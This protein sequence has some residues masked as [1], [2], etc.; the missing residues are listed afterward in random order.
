MEKLFADDSLSKRERVERT[1]N[2]Q[3]LDRAA[4]HEQLSFNAGVISLYTGKQF[5]GFTYTYDDICTVIRRTV[6]ACFPP[7]APLGT[8]RITDKDGFVIQRDNWHSMIVQR[9]FQDVAGARQFLLRKTEKMRKEGPL[10]DRIRCHGLIILS[11]L[12]D[13]RLLPAQ[14]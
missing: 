9:P 12:S 11:P 5:A 13:A 1:L 7:V 8:G 2:I 14:R 3:P 10:R 6:D 4:L